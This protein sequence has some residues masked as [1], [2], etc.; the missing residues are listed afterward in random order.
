M[1]KGFELM[2]I[3]FITNLTHL[4]KMITKFKEHLNTNYKCEKMHMII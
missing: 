4:V 3:V 1:V 2:K